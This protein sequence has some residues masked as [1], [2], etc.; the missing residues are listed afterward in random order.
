LQ[1]GRVGGALALVALVVAASISAIANIN[2]GTH[3]SKRETVIPYHDIIEFINGNAKG[4]LLVIS[5][6]PV[7]PW[8]LKAGSG[9]LCTGYFLSAKSCLVSGRHYDSI[10]VI[11]GHSDK[12][13][14]ETTM[15][16]FSNLVAEVTDGRSKLATFG[17]G[18]DQDAALKTGL[19]GVVLDKNILT[20]DYYR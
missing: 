13:A 17:A 14:N 18:L 9:D 10:F 1:R 20:V 12:S 2:F 3:P 6:D 16:N 4:S 19:T 15:R 11:S 5:T 7:I 8:V